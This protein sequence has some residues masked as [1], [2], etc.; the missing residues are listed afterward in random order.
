MGG[1]LTRV[2]P[3][4]G[5]C[6]IRVLLADDHALMRSGVKHIIEEAGVATVVAEASDGVEAVREFE[7]THPDVVVL[8]VSMPHM[9]GLEAI[10]HIMNLD[11]RARILVLTVHP[12]RQYAARFLKAG[13]LGY[14]TKGIGTCEL[15]EAIRTV[16][17]GRCY[18]ANEAKDIVAMQL[19]V[20][21]SNVAP[22]DRLSNREL[23][24]AC[25]IAHGK[26]VRD[27]A[28]ELGISI[29]TV[30]TYRSRLFEKLSA[31]SDAEICQFAFANKLVDVPSDQA[32]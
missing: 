23:Q 30:Y 29:K 22:M 7:R 18:L 9:D 31:H 26:R 14:V 32:F 24:I 16:A 17:G 21:R 27:I 8:D 10:K 25:L 4:K 6:M 20:S 28:D 1:L 12:E 3:H 2:Q 15:P 19:L 11:S 5:V 13:A